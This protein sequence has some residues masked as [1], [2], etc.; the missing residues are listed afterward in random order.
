MNLVAHSMGGIDARYAISK[1]GLHGSVASL[2]T[3]GTPHWGTPVAHGSALLFDQRLPLGRLLASLGADLDGLRE[4][5]PARMFEFNREVPDVRDVLYASYVGIAD[6]RRLRISAPL[7][8]SL[9]LLSA[10]VGSERWTGPGR[11]T[12]LGRG[13]GGDRG[14]PLGAD[15]LVERVRRGQ[16][17]TNEVALDLAERGY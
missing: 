12:T 2:T 16:V 17:S 6:A 10:G 1:L 9:L 8:P 5:T 7:W 13:A 4:L 3:I 14:R 15:R 11:L